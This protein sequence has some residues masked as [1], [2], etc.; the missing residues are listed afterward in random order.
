[1]S[2]ISRVIKKRPARGFGY[3]RDTV[4]ATDRRYSVPLHADGLH[5]VDLRSKVPAIL[6][7]GSTSSCVGHGFAAA[8]ALSE[9]LAGLEYEPVSPR[10]IYYNSRALHGDERYDEGTYLRTAADGLTKVGAPHETTCPTTAK[11]INQHPGPAA[12][13]EGHNRRDGIFER[14]TSTGEQRLYDVHAALCDGQPVVIGTGVTEAFMWSGRGQ[15]VIE[16]PGRSEQLIGGH[17]VLIVGRDADGFII[18]N[19]WGQWR[20][21]GFAWLTDEYIAWEGTSELVV[22]RDW[23][24][25]RERRAA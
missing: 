19:S 18:Q 2:W 14:I 3:W 10:A 23:N 20:E 15:R 16:R 22:L 9:S 4:L 21:G 25:L 11:L 8:I 7:Q 24:R 13:M 5:N 1:M 17:C 12:Y 6:D